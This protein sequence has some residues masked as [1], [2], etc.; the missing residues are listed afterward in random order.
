M[1]KNLLI[2]YK[3]QGAVKKNYEYLL[4]FLLTKAYLFRIARAGM[5]PR[6]S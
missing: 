5:F 3:I 2:Q 6:S 4:D 1:V